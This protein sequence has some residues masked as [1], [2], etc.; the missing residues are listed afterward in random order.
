M[1]RG[2]LFLMIIGLSV[3]CNKDVQKAD[4]NMVKGEYDW[5][6]SHNGLLES[7][8]PS[9][10]SEKFGIRINSKNTVKFYNDSEKV[11]SLKIN[12]MYQTVNG[13]MTI[14]VQWDDHVE[15]EIIIEENELRFF[16]WPFSG[17]HNSFRKKE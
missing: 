13:E 16:D 9:T 2:F 12:R 7:I 1:M 15:R 6:H 11:K 17:F 14:I 8:Y 4:L 10:I 5:Y 3:G